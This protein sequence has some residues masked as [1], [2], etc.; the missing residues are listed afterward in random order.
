M[1]PSEENSPPPSPR[2]RESAWCMYERPPLLFCANA[3]RHPVPTFKKFKII[4]LAARTHTSLRS[5]VRVCGK[6]HPQQP[7]L[8]LIYRGP[9]CGERDSLALIRKSKQTFDKGG[10]RLRFFFGTA[11]HSTQK[12]GRR[13]RY[14]IIWRWY[15]P[16][17]RER[18][19]SPLVKGVLILMTRWD[20]SAQHFER[21]AISFIIS[22][23]LAPFV[24]YMCGALG[25]KRRASDS[26]A[27]VVVVC[28][29]CAEPRVKR[30]WI[31][32]RARVCVHKK[33]RWIE[34]AQAQAAA[35]VKLFKEK[36]SFWNIWKETCAYIHSIVYFVHPTCDSKGKLIYL[37]FFISIHKWS[38]QFANYWVPKLGAIS[39][40]L[41]WNKVK[42]W[43]EVHS[44]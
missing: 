17:R 42:K 27:Q 2:R 12:R 9:A 15:A 13:R 6:F 14:N 41:N 25:R 33:R 19:L 7:N 8:Y 10:C 1:W 35:A 22:N 16:G 30:G 38:A 3:L 26:H 36:Q 11:A 5:R 31:F 34:R 29:L 21:A 20:M 28:V 37:F 39:L 24:S 4:S 44:M 43:K 23:I 32:M 18:V 40:P